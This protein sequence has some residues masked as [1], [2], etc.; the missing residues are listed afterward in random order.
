M[1][2]TVLEPGELVVGKYQ[3]KELLGRGGMGQVYLARHTITGKRVAIKMLAGGLSPTAHADKRLVREAVASGCIDHRHVVNVFDIG[4]HHGALFLVMEYLEGKSFKQLM[5]ERLCSDREL[6]E[7]LLRAMDGVRAAHAQG[8]VHRDLKPDNILVCQGP[9]GRYDDPKVVDFGIC[10]MTLESGVT[11]LTQTGV[12]M[13][14]PFYMSLE[15]LQGIRDL[16]GRADLYSIGVILYQALT[17]RRPFEAATLDELTAKI[18]GGI[19]PPALAE[20]RPDLPRG[21]S[22]V[23]MRALARTR[24]RRQADVATLIRELTPFVAQ[25]S[26]TPL[27]LSSRPLLVSATIPA[28]TPLPVWDAQRARPWLQLG[29]AALAAFALTL[30]GIS[31]VRSLAKSKTLGTQSVQLA[32][33]APAAIVRAE[34]APQAPGHLTIEAAIEARPAAQAETPPPELALEVQPPQTGKPRVMLRSAPRIW[35]KRPRGQAKF[36]APGTKA[37]AKPG[38]RKPSTASAGSAP[39]QNAKPTVVP[40]Q[41]M[42]TPQVAAKPPID[43]ND[44]YR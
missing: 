18:S 43:T 38:T 26:D 14:S 17:L 21:L 1:R 13:G 33:P 11:D 34:P 25:L 19:P 39:A 35:R 15:Q 6:L 10:R 36:A 9:T 37:T 20:L 41:S 22:K 23:V 16:D 42:T 28:N 3:V 44:P 5:Q 30:G 2:S 12:T 32:Q 7:I 29:A 31:F 40:G 27:S 24:D 4:E 8:V